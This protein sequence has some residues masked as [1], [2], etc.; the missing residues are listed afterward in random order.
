MKISVVLSILL[1]SAL[2]TSCRLST[3]AE[4]FVNEIN[5]KGGLYGETINLVKDPTKV[6]NQIVVWDSIDS[7][8][9]VVKLY[10]NR[11]LFAADEDAYA[12]YMENRQE[13]VP[14]GH[15]YYSGADGKLY[16]VTENAS[17]DLEKAQA[18]I[19]GVQINR[20]AEQAVAEF[21]LSEERGHA[22]ANVLFQFGRIQRNRSLTEN[23][24]RN[25]GQELVGS[26]LHE[27][28]AALL[29][30]AEGDAS[31]FDSLINKAAAFNK[32]TP[33]QMQAIV[34]TLVK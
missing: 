21:G 31:S 30:R 7:K 26:D 24:L 9:Y 32:V 10:G 19:D 16:E 17:K 15:G 3:K 1:L 29:A 33:E 11:H 25:L 27:F 23:D 14:A 34:E 12:Y 4:L 8:F 20:M 22:V 18:L 6:N 5:S 2:F 28:E 13:V